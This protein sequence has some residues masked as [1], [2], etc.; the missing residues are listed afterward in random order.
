MQKSHLATATAAITFAM[1]AASPAEARYLQT[2]PVGYKDGPN[3]YAY[4][5]NDPIN[6]VDPTGQT[7]IFAPGSNGPN[8]VC[9]RALLYQQLANDPAIASK[10]SFFSAASAIVNTLASANLGASVF[11]VSRDTRN[12]LNQTGAALEA[13]NLSRAAQIRA[14]QLFAGG[15]SIRSNDRA[16]VRFEQRQLQGHLDA[17]SPSARSSIV[18]EINGLLN[19]GALE[20]LGSALGLTDRNVRSAVS[21]VQ[22]SLGRDIDFGNYDDRVALGDALTS[23]ARENRNLCTGSRIRTC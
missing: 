18:G 11:S 22:E 4:V 23:M 19:G 14:G 2:D 3:L 13:S 1:M 10:T 9:Q 20:G 21:G 8:A 15:T 6:G 5:H 7:C 17:L 12:F 16:F